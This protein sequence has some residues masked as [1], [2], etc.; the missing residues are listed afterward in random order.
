MYWKYNSELAQGKLKKSTGG[1]GRALT[2]DERSTRLAA[3]AAYSG[4]RISGKNATVVQQIATRTA[5]QTAKLV[6]PIVTT[7]GDK[8]RRDIADL[9]AAVMPLVR[10]IDPVERVRA[11]QAAKTMQTYLTSVRS[12]L[13][14]AKV[15]TE[16]ERKARSTAKPK[17]H[18][19][20]LGLE[21][22]TRATQLAAVEACRQFVQMYPEERAIIENLKGLAGDSGVVFDEAE[23][24]A[25]GGASTASASGS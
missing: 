16:R 18:E 25:S 2:E 23:S 1:F 20:L 3:V 13:R 7:D 6:A 11:N 9:K 5:T 8:T 21:Q 17:S 12:L 10:R 14:S 22:N 24:A 15:A 19:Q 4:T